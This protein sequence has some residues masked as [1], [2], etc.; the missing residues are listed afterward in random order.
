MSN[1][2]LTENCCVFEGLILVKEPYFNEAGYD[3]QRG[4]QHGKENSR[5]YNEMAILKLIQV[6][7]TTL[8]HI[9][10]ILATNIC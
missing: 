4:S 1:A 5:M 2:W 3:R 10:N 8:V 9:D 6:S 7:R